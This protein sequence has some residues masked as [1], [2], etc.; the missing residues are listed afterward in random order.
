MTDLEL[1]AEVKTR[2]NIADEYHDD[3]LTALIADTKAFLSSAGVSDDVLADDMSVGCIA[4]GV[5]DMW[6]MGSG[7]GDFSPV[8]KMRATQL[9]LEEISED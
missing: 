2:L 3:L 1:L 5:A 8:F 4:R 6:N 7:D 9:A